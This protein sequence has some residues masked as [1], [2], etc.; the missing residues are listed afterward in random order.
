M[1]EIPDDILQAAELAWC[2]AHNYHIAD[3]DPIGV[4]AEAILAA[5]QAALDEAA[6][7][8]EDFGWMLPMYESAEVNEASDDAACEVQRQIAAAIRSRAA[9]S[10]AGA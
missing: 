6:K 1:S 5:R 9:L 7:L 3:G 8:A 10:K 2:N 4:I